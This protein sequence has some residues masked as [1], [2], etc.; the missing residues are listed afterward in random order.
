MSKVD[1]N[2]LFRQA[3][4]LKKSGDIQKAA[5]I[6]N[7]ILNLMPDYVPSINL[8]GNIYLDIDRL[9]LAEKYFQVLLSAD[10]QNPHFL[11]NQGK[12]HLPIESII[13]LLM[14][15]CNDCFFETYLF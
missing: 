3:V 6:C 15:F 14:I 4:A 8:L 7:Q 10:P 9:D 2:K 11:L 12:Y 13:L 5:E 1:L